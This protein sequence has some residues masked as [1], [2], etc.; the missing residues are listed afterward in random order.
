MARIISIPNQHP[1][2]KDMVCTYTNSMDMDA[3]TDYGKPDI[4]RIWQWIWYRQYPTDV[5][6]PVFFYG[7]SEVMKQ[8][9]PMNLVQLTSPNMQLVVHE[10][11]Q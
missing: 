5:D 6:Y 1:F 11:N 9:Y 3:D 4:R 8:D 7:L 10:F 2:F